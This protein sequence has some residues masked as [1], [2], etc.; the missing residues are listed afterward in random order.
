MKN[1]SLIFL[2]SRISEIVRRCSLNL[3]IFI[4]EFG[5]L[6]VRTSEG[7]PFAS[8]RIQQSHVGVYLLPLYHH[9]GVI[10]PFLSNRK[11]GKGTL[12]FKDEKDPAIEEIADL[13]ETCLNLV[14]KY[15]I[16]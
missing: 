10:G 3:D 5:D 7:R 14:G 11:S 8:V 4:H 1:D 12:Q 15:W 2:W 6:R 13:I 16:Y 9:P